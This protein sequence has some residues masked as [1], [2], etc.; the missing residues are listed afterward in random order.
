MQSKV[1][2]YFVI[3]LG[4]RRRP[5]HTLA[6]SNVSETHLVDKTPDQIIA[7]HSELLQHASDRAP[8]N[9]F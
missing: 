7:E 3:L 5:E 2:I 8:R 1:L 9:V 6:T 4:E